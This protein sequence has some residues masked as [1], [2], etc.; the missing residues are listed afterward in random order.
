MSKPTRRRRSFVFRYLLR[1]SWRALRMMLV[2]CCG[3]G[4]APPPPEP[5]GRTPVE[6]H[7]TGPARGAASLNRRA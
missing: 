1:P 6:Q 2:A 7:E 5:R 4:P 3:L